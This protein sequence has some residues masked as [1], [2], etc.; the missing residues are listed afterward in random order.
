MN[1][2][3]NIITKLDGFFVTFSPS[4]GLKEQKVFYKSVWGGMATIITLTFIFVYSMNQLIIWGSGQMIYK[5]STQQKLISEGSYL[6]QV[7]LQKDPHQFV[8]SIFNSTINPFDNN[9]MIIIPLPFLFN[10][11]IA[12]QLDY[13]E[14]E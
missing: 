4:F 1:T 2:F 7:F 9:Q 10:E 3:L 14:K 6:E 12:Y 11:Q 8:D 13:Q 5:V